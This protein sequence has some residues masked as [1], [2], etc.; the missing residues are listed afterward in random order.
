MLPSDFSPGFS[1]DFT[2][3]AHTSD[4]DGCGHRPNE[5]SPVPPSTFT[6]SRSPYAGEA[7]S[8]LVEGFFGAAFP[9]SSRLPC[10]S[11]RMTSSALPCSPSGANLSTLQDS[12]DVAGC[13]FAL[14]SQEVTTLQHNWSPE[15]TGCLL[16][17]AR[18]Q[19]CIL[20]TSE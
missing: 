20:K 18:P 12:L 7:C 4:Y 17:L 8:E 14:P 6:T 15:S 9:G 5:T 3:S 1:L 10:P 2:S 11:L 13:G 19:T 16:Y